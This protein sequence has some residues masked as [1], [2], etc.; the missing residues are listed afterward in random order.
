MKFFCVIGDPISHSKSPRIHNNAIKL[1]GLNGIYTRFHLKDKE[2]LKENL[3][4]LRLDGANITLPFKEE[5]LKIADFK[6]DLATQIGSANTLILKENRIYAYNTDASGFLKAIEEFKDVKKALI[7][8]AGG[9][10]RAI[11]YALK[12]KNIHAIIANRSEKKL[13]H[14]KD[15][16][17]M[18]YE[19]LKDFKFDIIIN[20]TSAG[21]N[22]DHL[23]CDVNLLKKIRTKYAFEVI[24][25]KKTPFIKFYEE[26]N[27]KHKDGLHMLLWQ[28]IFAFELFFDLKNQQKQIQ[29]AMLEALNLR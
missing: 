13:T 10:A 17:C 21:L 24:Y 4:K 18:L 9:T 29:K 22:D 11:A 26:K 28:G 6:D 2:K 1:L 20:S 23:P 16:Q 14:F 7:L 5:A 15:F 12:Q 25:G 3:F 8:G 27:I 19:N